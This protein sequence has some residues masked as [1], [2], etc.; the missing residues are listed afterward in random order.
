MDHK[1]AVDA[2]EKA[3]GDSGLVAAMHKERESVEF[4]VEMVA[5]QKGVIRA[6]RVPKDE[7][8]GNPTHDL[9]RIFYWGQNDFQP[10]AGRCSVSMGD[11]VRYNGQRWLCAMVGF[12]HL[13][14]EKVLP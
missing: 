2:A 7:L 9:E 5:F 8:D 12:E 3:A 10:V 1:L 14:G 11:I 4:E 6:V 13:A